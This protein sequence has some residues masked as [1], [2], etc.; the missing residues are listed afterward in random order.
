M[1]STSS[2]APPPPSPSETPTIN[3][4]TESKP[5]ENA[6][7]KGKKPLENN[8]HNAASSS[9]ITKED[10][11]HGGAL[12]L[13][14]EMI[15]KD[16][17][18][19]DS[20]LMKYMHHTYGKINQAREKFK[21]QLKFPSTVRDFDEVRSAIRK[22]EDQIPSLENNHHNAASS[23]GTTNEDDNHGGAL[24]HSSEMI[25]KD[26]LLLDSALME[27]M[28]HTYGKINQAR[29]KFKE[30][31]KLP[32]SESDFDEVRKVITKLKGQI[33]SHRSS[34]SKSQHR[35]WPNI[36][37]F[38]EEMM[39]FTEVKQTVDLEVLRKMAFSD[40]LEPW[41]RCLL[42]FF[43]FPPEKII[44]RTTMIYLW[45]GQGYISQ[46]NAGKKIFDELI[47]KHFIER[48]SAVPNSC[49]MKPS[50]RSFL[51]E[52]AEGKGFTSNG[53]PLNG[54]FLKDCR[55]LAGNSCRINSEAII[56]KELKIFENVE[57]IQ[58]LHLGR[59]QSSAKHHIE[60]EDIKILNGLKNLRLLKFLSLRGISMMTELP[61]FILELNC[62]EILD[63]RACHNLEGIADNIGLLKCL[64]HLDMSEC[65][66]LEHM[67]KSLAQL[68]NLEVLKGFFIGHLKKK[69]Q[70]CTLYDLSKLPKLRK[71]NIYTSVK[72]F[73]I[74][75]DLE[76][77]QKFEGLLK[78]TISWGGCSLKD[79]KNDGM[80]TDS[81]AEG[82]QTL[83]LRLQKLDLQGFPMKSLPHW[84]WPANLK[85]LKKLYIRGGNLCDLGQLQERPGEKWKVEI[86]RLKYLS[87]LEIE[88]NQ[89]RSLF[90]ELIYL[91]QLK[92]PK[93]TSFQIDKSG[94]WMDE[95]AIDTRFW[96]QKFFKTDGV[97][98]SSLV[99]YG[100][101][102]AQDDSNF[103][104][105]QGIL[106]METVEEEEYYFSLVY[107][108]QEIDRSAY[109]SQMKYNKLD[110]KGQKSYQSEESTII[111]YRCWET[112]SQNL[113]MAPSSYEKTFSPA[114]MLKSIWI[115][116]SIAA[117]LDYE[118]WQMNVKTA[119]LNE[120]LNEYIYMV[121]PDGFIA[122]EHMAASEAA[123]E[124]VW[125]RNF[126]LDLEVVPSVQS[127]I[128]L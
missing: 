4:S 30:L 97:S 83:H 109:Y 48:C 99:G 39:H 104:I 13:S 121:Q 36:N 45:I 63:L 8:H 14:S 113:V 95:K 106:G 92:C 77:L 58:S 41:H 32:S 42:C 55:G 125:L 79:E 78:L 43:R 54:D 50:V 120:N 1:A 28:H 18:L 76:A 111:A 61:A 33:P 56:N 103:S 6:D 59:W 35:E 102:L 100:P 10:D 68:S 49:R 115:L 51:S 86:L 25:Q 101:N 5:L 24:S 64:T 46:P 29:E 118:I 11:N 16:L 47:A 9:G 34:D 80:T 53:A 20:A 119:F 40:L 73:P 128:T 12:S 17:L 85:E 116:L 62:L 38:E 15:Q 7:Q 60:L 123:K 112:E 126:L 84:L 114:A 44:K 82:L 90:P 21:E 122:K 27:Y 127:P 88:W 26:L 107:L 2:E 89:L 117:H 87:E 19:L 31:P 74:G 93:L 94:V 75:S 72:K 81:R 70:S 105:E 69:K 37:E 65:Y 3:N 108:K 91:H 57:T 110:Q 66:F 52:L 96:L 98:L 22:L 71:L 23:C 67:P 124:A